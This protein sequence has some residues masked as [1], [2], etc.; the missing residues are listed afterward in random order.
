[1]QKTHLVLYVLINSGTKEGSIPPEMLVLVRFDSAEDFGKS[2]WF[3]ANY[4]HINFLV[5]ILRR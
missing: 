3:K 4:Q 1:M 2:D 5:I